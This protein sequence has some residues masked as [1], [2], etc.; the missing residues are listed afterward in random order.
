MPLL[1][2]KRLNLL[3]NYF[4]CPECKQELGSPI[5]KHNKKIGINKV[6]LVGRENSWRMVFCDFQEQLICWSYLKLILNYK[7]KNRKHVEHSTTSSLISNSPK[8]F[9]K[10]A[11]WTLPH[12]SLSPSTLILQPYHLRIIKYSRSCLKDTI[13]IISHRFSAVSQ[14]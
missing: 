14:I 12:F 5:S 11:R 13:S 7:P 8:I 9:K 2:Q 6:E 3:F 1:R 10:L 4:D